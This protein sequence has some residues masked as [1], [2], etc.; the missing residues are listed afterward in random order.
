MFPIKCT[1]VRRYFIHF[2]R[3]R[4]LMV[5]PVLFGMCAALDAHAVGWHFPPYMQNSGDAIVHGWSRM[6]G[7]P[8]ASGFFGGRWSSFAGFSNN[9]TYVKLNLFCII[10]YDGLI[11]FR[12]KS[13]IIIIQ[14]QKKW[15]LSKSC[16]KA[17]KISYMLVNN[18]VNNEVF[19]FCC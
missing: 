13:S 8:F 7:L 18:E 3:R 1:F 16:H 2:A 12:F 14:Y 4:V 17:E 10:R 6:L 5:R 11:L 9:A 15:I 19:M